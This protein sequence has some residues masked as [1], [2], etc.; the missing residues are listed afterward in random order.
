MAVRLVSAMFQLIQKGVWV[1]T[2]LEKFT[3][4]GIVV[5]AKERV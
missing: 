2:V 5:V 1:D 3:V 4:V